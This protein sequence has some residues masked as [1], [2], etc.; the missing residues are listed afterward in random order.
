MIKLPEED[1]IILEGRVEH[2]I[3]NVNRVLSDPEID[4]WAKKYW[5]KVK[6]AL[7]MKMSERGQLKG[8]KYVH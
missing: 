4:D 7:I 8:S 5:T 6:D 1:L 2:H 3:D